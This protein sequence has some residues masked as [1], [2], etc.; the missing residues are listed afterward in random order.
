M[1]VV[2]QEKPK[3]TWW[4]FAFTGQKC[5]LGS[6]WW[7]LREC[8]EYTEAVP[9]I[10][11]PF[12]SPLWPKSLIRVKRNTL[13]FHKNLVYKN[14]KVWYSL[15]I[16]NNSKT[17]CPLFSLLGRL[18]FETKNA[19]W[20]TLTVA[21]MS[22]VAHYWAYPTLDWRSWKIYLKGRVS[23]SLIISTHVFSG[24]KTC[25]NWVCENTR[26]LSF[27]LQMLAGTRFETANSET[28]ITRCE[29]KTHDLDW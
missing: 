10:L 29:T 28:D 23:S 16:K 27:M 7:G 3:R 18:T 17:I 12:Q 20:A 4:G 5:F 11:W 9:A 2:S 26:E 15:K 22:D 8:W 25:Y 6:L 19:V 13:F 1:V 24:Y 21:Q 14:I